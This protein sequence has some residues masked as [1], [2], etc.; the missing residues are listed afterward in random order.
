MKFFRELD[1]REYEGK[2]VILDLDGTLVADGSVLLGQEEESVLKNLIHS[3]DRVVILSNSLRDRKSELEARY[4]ITVLQSVVSK[5]SRRAFAD[6]APTEEVVVIG[7]KVLTDGLFAKNI[8]GQFVHVKHLADAKESLFVRVSYAVD[9]FVTVLFSL[10][11][12]VRLARPKQWVK[13]LLLFAPLFFAGKL[14]DISLLL[15]VSVAFVSLSL[16]ASAGY[17][18]NDIKDR[19]SDAVHPT[20]YKRPV[21]SGIVSVRSASYF[22]T[23]LFIASVALSLFVPAVL[24]WVLAYAGL[25]LLY[26]FF[27]KHVPV[28]EM[29]SI[30]AFFLIRIEAGG[31]V[32]GVPVSNWLVLVTFFAAFFVASCKRYAE[33]LHESK[34][35]RAVVRVYSRFFI[36]ALPV[37]AGILLIASYFLYS[38]FGASFS[39]VMYSTIFVVF[40]VLWYLRSM[41]QG[42]TEEPDVRLWKDPV[43]FATVFLWGIYIMSVFYWGN[44]TVLF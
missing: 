8:G 22:A 40:G 9:S 5:P 36:T 41:Y 39:G 2:T 37:C 3:A 21:A 38:I 20:K 12:F 17:A 6:I 26:S 35:T 10:S 42:A 11:P 34:R 1:V 13:N 25:S 31:V 30:A 43:L 32:A 28:V 24:P 15:T 23:L 4:G 44:L 7:D 27:L 33:S 19:A 18:L 16:L 29:L 14:F